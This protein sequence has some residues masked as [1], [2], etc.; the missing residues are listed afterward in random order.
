MSTALARPI[1]EEVVPISKATAPALTLIKSQAA[2]TKAE[3]NPFVVVFIAALVS[4]M[5][6]SAMIGT[7]AAWIYLLR[8][9]GAFTP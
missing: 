5:I 4:L 1:V 3:T 8:H 9:S 2:E 7:L 6:S